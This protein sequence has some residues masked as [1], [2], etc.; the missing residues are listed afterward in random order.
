[1]FTVSSESCFNIKKFHTNLCLRPLWAFKNG[2]ILMNKPRDAVL[3]D[4]KIGRGIATFDAGGVSMTISE[5]NYSVESLVSLNTGT[6]YILHGGK[7]TRV[8]K[9]DKGRKYARKKKNSGII[10]QVHVSFISKNPFQSL[11]VDADVE[12]VESNSYIDKTSQEDVQ[13]KGE[14]PNLYQKQQQLRQNMWSLPEEIQEEIILRLPVA[15]VNISN[16]D[17]LN[18]FHSIV[19]YP[20]ELSLCERPVKRDEKRYQCIDILGY[21]NGLICLRISSYNGYLFYIWNPYTGEYKKIP[22]VELWEFRENYNI[23]E[24]W[25]RYGFGYDCVRDDYRFVK[26]GKYRIQVYTLG[27]DSW[28][29]TRSIPYYFPGTNS[30]HDCGV[31][32]NGG[33]YCL[34]TKDTEETSTEVIESF[35]ISS[36]NIVDVP[37]PKTMP[38]SLT[39]SV[40][41]LRDCLCLL[42]R[43]SY[44]D[45]DVWVMQAYG[46]RESWTKTFTI[47]SESDSFY[48]SFCPWP[49]WAFQNG[50][51]LMDKSRDAVLRD[52]KIGRGLATFD[53]G[54]LRMSMSEP[55]Y[56]MESLVSLD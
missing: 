51:I 14:N 29:N 9:E 3:C 36:E 11:S 55:N 12:M 10:K 19:D 16:W 2:D 32:F 35:D 20:R 25:I 28:N 37:L 43:V 7:Y 34:C 46:V 8:A 21:C 42:A 6:Y 50:E 5:P 15:S 52:L 23:S 27:S 40:G 38:K 30:I 49:V 56:S 53:A 48:Q 31:P 45:L 1:M 18:I 44:N 39:R 26:I 54:S 13:G 47:G 4:L 17:P 33:L 24:W 41:V 22:R